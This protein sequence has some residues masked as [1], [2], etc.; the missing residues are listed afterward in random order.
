M[1]MLKLQN[2]FSW[3]PENQPVVF[4][5]QPVIFISSLYKQLKPIEIRERENHT[6]KFILL[7]S[8]TN[9]YIQSPKTTGY[10]TMQPITH[11]HTHTK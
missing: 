1:R 3:F 11:T 9:S 7:H 4:S 10:S 2:Y 5:I 6:N 8:Y